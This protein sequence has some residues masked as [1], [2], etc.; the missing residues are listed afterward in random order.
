MPDPG[1]LPP[2][3]NLDQVGELRLGERRGPEFE[4]HRP[5]FPGRDEPKCISGNNHAN[6]HYSN[7]KGDIIPKASKTVVRR[8]NTFRCSSASGREHAC[9]DERSFSWSGIA[10]ISSSLGSRV[11]ISG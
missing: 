1:L 11:S 6:V 5:A 9:S 2:L 3:R 10:S 8:G 7:D 4:R